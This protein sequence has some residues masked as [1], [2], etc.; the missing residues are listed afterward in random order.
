[1]SWQQ[2]VAASREQALSGEEALGPDGRFLDPAIEAEY[3][4]TETAARRRPFLI[5]LGI[6]AAMLVALYP[7]DWLRLEGG[8]LVSVLTVRTL[9]LAGLLGVA[10][11]GWRHPRDLD[12]IAPAAGMLC[13]VATLALTLLYGTGPDRGG[14]LANAMQFVFTGLIFLLLLPA[15]RRARLVLWFVATAAAVSAAVFSQNGAPWAW[16]FMS[17]LFSFGVLLMVLVVA[18]REDRLRRERFAALR[19][20]GRLAVRDPLTGAGNR[21]AFFDVAGAE[22]DRAERSGRPIALVLFD[23]DWFKVFNDNHG[24]AM[25]DEVLRHLVRLVREHLRPSDHLARLGGEEFALFLPDTDLA[26]AEVV[27]ERLRAALRQRP[28]SYQG[29]SFPVT[30]SLGIS[31]WRPGEPVDAFLGRADAALYRAKAEG[32]DRA[33]MAS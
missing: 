29:R 19:Q 17:S 7:L 13:L 16:V 8:Q 4:E 23:V 32:R 27:A 3:A 22:M 26:A 5:V 9:F 15:S 25:G 11:R 10:W 6:I 12:R 14:P 30:V 1:M 24:H 31:L 33:V 18:M 28:A 21:R 20:I 2:V